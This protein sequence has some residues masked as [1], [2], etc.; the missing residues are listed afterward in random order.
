M[1][2]K[3]IFWGICLI[4]L[5]VL[6]ILDA[7]HVFDPL[8]A[9]IGK[10]SVWAMLSG[11]ALL[12]LIANRLYRGR[13]S[14]IFIPLALIFMLFE[15][16]ISVLCG[17]VTPNIINN[18]LLLLIAVLFTAGFSLLFPSRR[19]NHQAHRLGYH[20]VSTTKNG[21]YAESSLGS[22]AVYIESASFSP[23]HVENNLGSCLVFF[24]NPTAYT[25]NGTL[26]VENNLGSMTIYVPDDWY[27]KASL[28]NN[29]GGIHIPE[30][31]AGMTLY[32][33]G[34]NNLGSVTV[35]YV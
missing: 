29:L 9:R 17:A 12:I 20:A 10:I 35:I 15:K 6:L 30:K 8:T 16:N 26:Y 31:D 14:H 18:W 25:G 13:V 27:V 11:I 5:S 22:A 32:L 28:E 33:K 3:K 2:S 1:K 21:R 4:A 23:D 19:K 34:E 7:F 24:E